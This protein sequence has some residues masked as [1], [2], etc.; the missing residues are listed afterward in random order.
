MLVADEV[1]TGFGR[2][3]RMFAMEHYG[4]EADLMIVAKSI[5]AG[6]PLSGVVGKA[7]LMDAHIPARSA[8][9]TSGI[10]SP[11]RRRWRCSTSSPR[12]SSSARAKTIGQTIR[13]RM[14]AWQERWPRVGDVRGLGAMLAIELV[15]DPRRRRPPRALRPR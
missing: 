3:G 14:L 5:A 15:D 4:V 9:P 6:L 7:E 2:T 13:E 12:R 10:R 8:A 11:W 1:Q